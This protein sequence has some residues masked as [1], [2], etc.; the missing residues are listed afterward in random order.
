MVRITIGKKKNYHDRSPITIHK[1]ILPRFTLFEHTI[2]N[3]TNL[4]NST[5]PRN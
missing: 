1:A 3:Q 2:F 4:L 5:N